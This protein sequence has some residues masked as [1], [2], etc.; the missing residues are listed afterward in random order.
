MFSKFMGRA[1]LL[2]SSGKAAHFHRKQCSGCHGNEFIYYTLSIASSRTMD[3]ET[4]FRC[5]GY[6]FSF[7]KDSTYSPRLPAHR[8]TEEKCPQSRMGVHLLQRGTQNDCRKCP[9][10]F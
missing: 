5:R 7:I 9:Q 1:G 4:V 3:T 2:K 6:V 10:V 8:A